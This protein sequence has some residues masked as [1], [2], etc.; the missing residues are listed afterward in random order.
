MN[1][2]VLFVTPG[3]SKNVKQL[4]DI[5]SLIQSHFLGSDPLGI[6]FLSE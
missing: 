4:C 5:M 3:N 2:L 1:I 6:A